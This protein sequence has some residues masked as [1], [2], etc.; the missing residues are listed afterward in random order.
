MEKVEKIFCGF[1]NYPRQTKINMI[2]D[3]KIQHNANIVCYLC[4]DKFNENVRNFKKAGHYTTQENLE[5]LSIQYVIYIT[6]KALSS[7]STSECIWI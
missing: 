6:K 4:G 1:A 5:A 2:C 3:D 7:N